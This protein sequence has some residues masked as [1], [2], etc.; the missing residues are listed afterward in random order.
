MASVTVAPDTFE[1]VDFDAAEIAALASEVCDTLG[2][3]A[4]A[5]L[6]IE[7]DEAVML[8]RVEGVSVTGSEV[9]VK[10]TGGA[11]ED[12]R[13]ARQLSAERTRN[14][15]AQVLLRAGDRLTPAFADAPTDAELTTA[16]ASAWDTYTDGRLARMG[17]AARRPRRLYHFRLRHGFTDQVDTIFDHLWNGESLTW[18]EVEAASAAARAAGRDLQTLTSAG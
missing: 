8:P 10:V 5:R 17:I 7:I 2:L 9:T 11:L 4:D 14:T 15:L 1:L 16:Q 12:Q 18:D 3:P 13:R 6:H